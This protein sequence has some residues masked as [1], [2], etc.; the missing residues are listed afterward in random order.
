MDLRV[1][2]PLLTPFTSYSEWK[3]KMISSL[4]RQGIH[5]VYIGNGKGSYEYENNWINN[6]KVILEYVWPFLQ[7]YTILL[8]LLTTPKDLWIEFDRTFGNKNEDH[9]RNLD[10]IL[11]NTRVL[12]SKFTASIISYEVV[13]YEEEESSTQ[14][15]RIEESVLGVTPPVAPNVY[16]ISDIYYSHMDDPK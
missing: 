7:T 10:R 12:Y 1:S 13:Q 3:F 14:S 8:I 16:E 9:Y 11:N 4:K 2:I 5:E 15:I 6:V